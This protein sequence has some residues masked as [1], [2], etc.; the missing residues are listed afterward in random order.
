MTDPFRSSPQNKLP[1][2]DAFFVLRDCRELY[3]KRLAE[4][5]QRAGV[6]SPPLLQS[7]IDALGEAH[8][9]LAASRQNDAFGQTHGL[10]SSRITL[11]CDNDLELEIRIGDIAR[12]L[13]EDAGKPLWRVHHR[14][15]TLLHR[16]E[17]A[18]A[19]NP[20][21]PEAVCGS[22]WAL[23]SSSDISLERKLDLLDRVEE[24]LTLSLPLIYDELNDLLSRRGI[25]PAQSPIGSP[26]SSSAAAA[27]RGKPDP[28]AGLQEV[29]GKQFSGTE[30]VVASGLSGGSE[31]GAAA[32]AAL[33][34]ATLLML[35][36]LAAR[37]DQIDFSRMAPGAADA[38]PA[39]SPH[40]LKSAEVGF[41]L[42]RNEAVA[43]D[44]LAHIFDAI[45]EIWELPDTVKTAIGRLQIPFL[46][47]AMADPTL[48]SD[49]QHP[50]R[51]LINGMA[52]ATI[53]LPRDISRS[54]PVSAQ[55]WLLA[56]TVADSLQGDASVL[57]AP[58]AELDRLV[59][60]R[61]QKI[62]ETAQAF[63]TQLQLREARKT[64]VPRV[65]DWLRNIETYAAPP[66]IHRFLRDDW[67]R[68]MAAACMEGEAAETRWQENLATAQDLL[69]S[70]QPKSTPEERK[71]LAGMA[72]SLIKRIA[73]GQER[74][75]IP[76]ADRTAFI[77]S[78]FQL[79]TNALRGVA[80]ESSLAAPSLMP[81]AALSEK[82]FASAETG[83]E[84][85]TIL[86]LASPDAGSDDGISTAAAAPVGQ[87]LQ[88][89]MHGNEQ[90]CGLVCWQ[91]PQTGQSLLYNPDWDCAISL[92][93]ALL[94]QQ[95]RAAQARV[96][97]SQ[98]IFDVAAAHALKQ[99]GRT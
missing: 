40:T 9:E 77:D 38:Q 83:T 63:V 7:F 53:G 48:F 1:A 12:R 98:A 87:W 60:G 26:P 8:D 41:P 39:A 58:L 3:Q 19:D 10:T 64:A 14:Y 62:Q 80:N 22:L 73:A 90:L 57:E 97:S 32:Q 30:P 2:E 92:P 20:I 56:G 15:M 21:G 6:A 33:N 44:T 31:G 51:R 86:V 45:F 67:A 59:A 72:S 76:A 50:A 96:V 84:A 91:S 54:H 35:N 93:A 69:W 71:R 85:L 17:M 37:L 66:E 27:S 16:P 99:I 42:A 11:M 75:G 24:Q 36:Q 28:L 18:R 65:L 49:S 89:V 4:T 23:C 79:Q 46:K 25:E 94:E 43:L 68:V 81:I 34:P 5:V 55:L 13:G 52:R 82:L 61:D 74:V 95:L 47:L 78:C 88:F 29:L 70:V